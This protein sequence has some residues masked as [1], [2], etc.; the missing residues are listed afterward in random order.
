MGRRAY[1]WYLFWLNIT[2]VTLAP[3]GLPPYGFLWI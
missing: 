3:T 1:I 2:M